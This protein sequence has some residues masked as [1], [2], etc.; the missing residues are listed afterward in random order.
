MKIELESK[1]KNGGFCA[2][3]S[4]CALCWEGIAIFGHTPPFPAFRTGVSD[5]R[6][7]GI[8][9]WPICRLSAFCFAGAYRHPP[10]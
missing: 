1:S 5:A 4:Y 6:S 8:Y 10:D 9:R 3:E 7:S 2:R